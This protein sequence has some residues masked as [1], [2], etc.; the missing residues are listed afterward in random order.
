M[1]KVIKIDLLKKYKFELGDK[2]YDVTEPTP[3]QSI[4]YDEKIKASSEDSKLVYEE[5]RAFLQILGIP[6]DLGLGLTALQEILKHI[7]PQKKS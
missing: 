5:T 2:I 7:T 6:K 4:E 3:E 1:T